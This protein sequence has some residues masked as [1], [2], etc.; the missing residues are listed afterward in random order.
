M[1]YSIE[2]EPDKKKIYPLQVNRKP[3]WLVIALA[4]VISI[5]L[6]QKLDKNQVL[7]SLLIPGDPE[8]TAAAFSEMMDDIRE[9]QAVRK[10]VTSFCLEIID[11]G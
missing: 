11:N 3:K 6:M 9:G 4:V 5:F 7:K 10:A 2:Y 1:S 8:I